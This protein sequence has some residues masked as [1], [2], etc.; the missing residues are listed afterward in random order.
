MRAQSREQHLVEVTDFYC[1][2]HDTSSTSQY[3]KLTINCYAQM[4]NQLS[5][6]YNKTMQS[7]PS[8]HPRLEKKYSDTHAI[9]AKETWSNSHSKQ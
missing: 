3:R 2:N 8:S 1:M 9:V 4:D 6:T 7:C 5:R